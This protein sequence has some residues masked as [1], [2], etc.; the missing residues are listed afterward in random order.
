MWFNWNFSPMNSTMLWYLTH[1]QRETNKSQ[2]N[3]AYLSPHTPLYRTLALYIVAKF[4]TKIELNLHW[5][6]HPPPLNPVTFNYLFLRSHARLPWWLTG[7]ESTCQCRRQE[8]DSLP[9]RSPGNPLQCSCLETPWTGEPGGLQSLGSQ[10]VRHDLATKR[11]KK[12]CMLSR[13]LETREKT[14]RALLHGLHSPQQ[15]AKGWNLRSLFWW[16]IFSFL[17]E[18][19][20]KYPWRRKWQSTPVFLPGKSHGWS[21]RVGHDWTTSLS[22]LALNI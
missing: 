5:K 13:A 4:C 6:L 18:F 17:W 16:I 21:Q 19:G 12:D 2:N 22:L 10:K 14:H 7:K 1:R 9:G 8:F 3:T 20:T 11:K 15:H